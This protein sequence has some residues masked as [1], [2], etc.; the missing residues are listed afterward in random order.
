MKIKEALKKLYDI[1]REYAIDTPYVVGGIPR[2][3]YIGEEI[4]TKDIDIT[5]NTADVL[6]LA[7]LF[8][9]KTGLKLTL[10]EDGHA[11]VFSDDFKLDFSTHTIYPEVVEHLQPVGSDLDVKMYE[12]FSRDF[13]I[14]TLHMHPLTEDILDPTGKGIADIKAKIIKTPVPAEI[15]LSADPR[16]A[17]R[18]VKFAVQYDFDIDSDI[19]SF[20]NDN[21]ELFKNSDIDSFILDTIDASMKIDEDRTVALLKEMGLFKAVPLAGKLKDYLIKNHSVLEYFE[22]KRSVASSKIG[23]KKISEVVAKNWEEYEA[24]GPDFKELADFWKL[25]WRQIPGILSSDYQSWKSWYKKLFKQEWSEQHKNPKEVLDMLQQ[26]ISSKSGPLQSV[27]VRELKVGPEVNRKLFDISSHREVKGIPISGIKWFSKDDRGVDLSIES[28]SFLE[29]LSDKI[30]FPVVIT[31]GTRT[32]KEQAKAMW[33]NLKRDGFA[34]LVELYPD[35][36]VKDMQFA[37]SEKDIENILIEKQNE[38][39]I[40]AHLYGEGLDFSI[41]NL[42]SEEKVALMNAAK[43]VGSR[44]IDEHNHIHVQFGKFASI[45]NRIVKKAIHSFVAKNWEQYEAQG[46][47]YKDLANYW[48]NNWDQIPG[49]KSDSFIDWKDWYKNQFHEAW[50]GKHKSPEEVLQ[51]FKVPQNLEIKPESTRMESASQVVKEKVVESIYKQLSPKENADIIMKIFTS[52][53]FSQN[54]AKAAIVNAQAES[55]LNNLAIGDG[56][57]SLGLFQLNDR[58]AGRNIAL[59]MVNGEPDLNDPRFDPE[60][61][62][63]EIIKEINSPYGNRLKFADKN[64]EPI[65]VLSQIFSEDIERP[66]DKRRQARERRN[67]SRKL[68]PEE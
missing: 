42:S 12:V 28:L 60:K 18:A 1:S 40:S 23:L 52:N 37:K 33:K 6:M 45:E 55:G 43:E 48:K 4:E 7:I 41:R 35:A 10:L 5:T 31:S 39:P 65:S 26:Y 53:G 63:L 9:K 24:Q 57:H 61:N 19:I 49:A 44:V 25:N 46:E 59:P 27:I 8:S 32:L 17:F 29:K 47:N 15:T 13:T 16:R 21:F 51:L 66:A 50:S 3:I 14:N 20:C 30:N 64:R 36:L 54:I 62:T 34:R 68:F 11:I 2:D 38:M 67:L 56:G 58:G 22:E